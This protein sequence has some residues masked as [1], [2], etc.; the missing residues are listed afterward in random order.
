MKAERWAVP[1]PAVIPSG[2]RMMYPSDE[3]LS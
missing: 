3:G 2:D 1:K